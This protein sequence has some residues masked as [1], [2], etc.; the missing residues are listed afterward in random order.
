MLPVSRG[1]AASLPK[2][3]SGLLPR[4]T[5]ATQSTTCGGNLPAASMP[6]TARRR[7]SKVV[8]RRSRYAI[9]FSWDAS[10]CNAA[11]AIIPTAVAANSP[12]PPGVSA[13]AP[14]SAL[15][16]DFT[17][18]KALSLFGTSPPRYRIAAHGGRRGSER[19]SRRCVHAPVGRRGDESAVGLLQSNQELDRRLFLVR[20]L[21]E[22]GRRNQ[23]KGQGEDAAHVT[24]L[25]G[26]GSCSRE[27]RFRPSNERERAN[28]MVWR[29]EPN[30]WRWTRCL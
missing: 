24:D 15:R 3:P 29:Q 25:R 6:A 8:A 13:N 18:A 1:I 30:R 10:G 14:V 22:E 27:F 26:R 12:L 28:N 19:R 9:D 20:G 2:V 5:S 21:G 16:Q 17:N 7:S 11:R 4:F 23:Q